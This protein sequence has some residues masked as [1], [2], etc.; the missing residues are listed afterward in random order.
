M[1]KCPSGKRLYLTEVLAEEALIEA[2][3]QF[4]FRKGSGPV[5]VYLCDDCGVYHLTSRGT[6]NNRLVQLLE[7]GKIH[8][9]RE[10]RH[11][12]KQWK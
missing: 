8:R 2:H 10:A 1:K 12:S 6:M 11:W 3:I 4:N 9:Q 5:A 7:E